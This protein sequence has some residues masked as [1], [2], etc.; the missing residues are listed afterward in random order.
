MRSKQKPAL[1]QSWID[2]D[3]I[4]IVK[5]LTTKGF[6]TYLVGGCVRDLLVGIHPKDFDIATTAKPEEV[7]RIIPRSYI[8]GKRFRLVLVR[9]GDRQ[10]E[11]ATFRRTLSHEEEQDLPEDAPSGDNFFGSP[12]EDASRR[13]FT[14]NSLFYN[15]VSEEVIDYNTGLQD[16]E[17]RV[18]KMIGPAKE[19]LLEDPIRILRA[20]RL[21]HK[22]GFSMDA[23]IREAIQETVSSLPT[24]VLPRRREEIL[25]FLRLPHPDVA[26][27]EAH[28]LGIL[29]HLIPTLDDIYQDSERREI[30]ASYIERIPRLVV[31]Q[32]SPIELFGLLVFA[33]L[34][35]LTE[36]D[37]QQQL[38]KLREESHESFLKD[39][40][41]MFKYEQARLIKALQITQNLERSDDFKRKGERRQM[42]LLRN[43]AF[44]LALTFAEMDY[45]L[46]TQDIAFW[47]EKYREALPQIEEYERQ[48][49]AKKKP[50]RRRKKKRSF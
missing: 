14:I 8:I 24:S 35:S 28:D 21:S 49:A 10:F 12:E 17:E 11:V 13:D 31:D 19:R 42:A 33:Y 7:K 2:P 23:E 37:N 50:P 34:R 9:R 5:R 29:K 26:F 15:P 27:Q 20:L 6:T 44:P 38:K 46:N 32:E 45:L 3:A 18:L 40:L 39:E 30:F 41:G 47:H 1:H 36:L 16:I 43:E 4:D 22:I 48:K 25:K